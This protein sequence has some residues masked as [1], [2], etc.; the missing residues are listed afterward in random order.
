M[1]LETV[2]PWILGPVLAG[3]VLLWV[4]GT[5]YRMLGRRSLRRPPAEEPRW[6]DDP[7]YDPELAA[8][9]AVGA[10]RATRAGEP[11]NVLPRR[12]SRRHAWAEAERLVKAEDPDMP[13]EDNLRAALWAVLGGTAE[14][15]RPALSAV[16]EVLRR[17]ELAGPDLWR[18]A[19]DE[20]ASPAQRS[21]LHQVADAVERA[22]A[23][24]RGRG[25]LDP[26]ERVPSV[27]AAQWADG[28]HLARTGLRIG[29]MSGTAAATHVRRAGALAGRWYPSWRVLRAAVLLPDLL[30]VDRSA[31][32]WGLRVTTRLAAAREPVLG[33][34][35][36]DGH[37]R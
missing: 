20:S 5:A 3:T 34:P 10:L 26:G 30:S 28:V 21:L 13:V 23:E 7:S 24:L 32:E 18:H 31:A 33:A 11:V 8:G 29:M 25:V 14:V 12:C 17:R 15:V 16:E 22:E 36:A 37:R 1:T 9:L 6:E 35:E 4:Y 19:L 2:L 27:L